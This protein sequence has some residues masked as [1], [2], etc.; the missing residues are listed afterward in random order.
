VSRRASATREATPASAA[1]APEMGVPPRVYAGMRTIA[2]LFNR[3]Y[4]RVSVEGTP[5][6]AR[7]PVILAPVHRSFIDFFVVS[8]VTKR[9]IFFMTKEEMWNSRLLGR[10]LDS[11]GAFPVRR[12]G[13]DRRSLEMAQAV[14]LHGGVLVLFPEGTRRS[15]SEVTE[16]H[17]G[18]AFLAA[19]TG[20][21]VVPVGIG[22]TAQSLPKG[23]KMP[24]PVPVHLVVGN[25][26]PVEPRAKGARPSRAELRKI[27]EQVR[28]EL[29]RVYDLART[30]PRVAQ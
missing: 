24:R 12:E 1:G 3:A 7:G 27:T 21:T 6:P 18:T 25:P 10:F 17:E 11:T 9:P 13:A 15:G 16:L 22:G 5:V 19:R 20:A 26:I 30:N 8:E 29:Q 14:L 28:A 4:W 23:S 2:H